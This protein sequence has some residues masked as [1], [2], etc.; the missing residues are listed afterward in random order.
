[1]EMSLYITINESAVND[2]DDDD[3]VDKL[4]HERYLDTTSCAF[5]VAGIFV[6]L[7][8]TNSMPIKSPTPLTSPIIECFRA[9]CRKEF[10][11]W[12]PTLVACSR[13][14]CRSITSSTAL[15][16]AHDTGFPP[17]CKV[18]QSDRHSLQYKLLSSWSSSATLRCGLWVPIQSSSIP[19]SLCP[20]LASFLIPQNTNTLHKQNYPSL[21][22]ISLLSL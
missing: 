22:N 7:S 19:D 11:T 4:C 17:Y 16:V 14:F 3:D 6:S 8:S 5:A 9:S 15:A 20:L 2:D 12:F 21:P 18:H 1:M 10:S 13:S